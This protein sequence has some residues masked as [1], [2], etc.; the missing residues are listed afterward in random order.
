MKGMKVWFVWE[1]FRGARGREWR[2]V[3]G[4]PFDSRAGAK[5]WTE[6]PDVQVHYSGSI[7]QPGRVPPVFRI[8]SAIIPRPS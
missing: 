8:V 1:H 5:R 4:P 2:L 6:H 3:G 7:Y